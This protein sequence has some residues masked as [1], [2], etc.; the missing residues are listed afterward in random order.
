MYTLNIKLPS[1][2]KREGEVIASPSVVAT[3][4][5]E[6]YSGEVIDTELTVAYTTTKSDTTV[7]EQVVT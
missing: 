6:N 3:D 7:W 5:T 2:G 1:W 4:K